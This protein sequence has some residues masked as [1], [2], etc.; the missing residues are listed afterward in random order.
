MASAGCEYAIY[1]PFTN[2]WDGNNFAVGL[3][4]IAGWLLKDRW[5]SAF[6][7][8]DMAIACL[9]IKML[10]RNGTALAC[11]NKNCR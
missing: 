9:K 2:A 8:W 11:L 3:L 10:E 4:K 6:V 1:I 5:V 7:I